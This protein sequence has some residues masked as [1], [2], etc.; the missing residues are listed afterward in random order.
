M[1]DNHLTREQAIAELLALRAAGAF[2]RVESL[3]GKYVRPG[4]D[5]SIED[6]DAYLHEIG[7]EWEQ[8]LDDLSESD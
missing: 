1:D 5:I 3:A 6:L 7:T 8:D 4:I 2:E